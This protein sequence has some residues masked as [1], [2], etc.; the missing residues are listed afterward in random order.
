[1]T[2]RRPAGE[3]RRAYRVEV[4]LSLPETTARRRAYTYNARS[5]PAPH[6]RGAGAAGEGMMGGIN[7]NH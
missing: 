3:A 7:A 1:M 5:L 6:R 2:T 4:T